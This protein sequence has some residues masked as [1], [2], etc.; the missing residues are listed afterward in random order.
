MKIIYYTNILNCN[1]IYFLNQFIF[2]TEQKSKRCECTKI[3]WNK[4][5][6]NL[7]DLC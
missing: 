5:V 3:S 1:P 7:P 4:I 2:F 6:E